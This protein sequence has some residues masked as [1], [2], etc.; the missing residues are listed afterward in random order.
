MLDLGA[1]TGALTVPLAAT[2]A[3]VIAVELHPVR[4]RALR[5][6]VCGNVKVVEADAA[7]MALPR[8]PFRVVA[9]PPFS[10]STSIIRHLTSRGSALVGADVLLPWY[11]TKRWLDVRHGEWISSAGLRVPARAFTPLAPD[12]V[13]VLRLRRGGR[14]L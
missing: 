14:G 5:E 7:V 13:T 1:G 3:R 12:G 8:R 2:G 11:L 10:I 6:A 4:A 9:N